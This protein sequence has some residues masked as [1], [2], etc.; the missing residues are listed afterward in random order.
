MT[1]ILELSKK[2]FKISIITMLNDVKK[3]LTMN[4]KIKNSQYRNKNCRKK[5]NK[6]E[7]KGTEF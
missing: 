2:Y 1:Q 5:K 7:K 3:M 6:G 4:E